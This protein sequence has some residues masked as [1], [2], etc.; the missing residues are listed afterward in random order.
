MV[1]LP[2]P[3]PAGSEAGKAGLTTIAEIG[4]ERLRRVIAKMKAD[5]DPQDNEDLGFKVFKLAQSN[6]KQWDGTPDQTPEA[7]VEQMTMFDDSL[8]DGWIPENVIYEVAIK[9]GYPLTCKVEALQNVKNNRVY[10]VS[11]DEQFFF[12]CLDESLSPG[13]LEEL[14]L[15]KSSLF[16]CLDSAL[17]DE[18]AA[19]LT[20]QCKLK[21]I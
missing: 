10:K 8:V 18:Q 19:N 2:E 11:G 17:T 16:V 13:M 14:K 5:A 4:K 6:Y 1:Q 9:E 21:T 7:Y 20:L 12:I 15:E 3:V